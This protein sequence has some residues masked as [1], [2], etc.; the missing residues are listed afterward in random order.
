MKPTECCTAGMTANRTRQRKTLPRR[1]YAIGTHSAK[2]LEQ[3]VP[4]V[5]TGRGE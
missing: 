1:S 4:A 3:Q 5:K 2:Q